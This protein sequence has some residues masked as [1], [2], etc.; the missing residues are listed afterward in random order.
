MLGNPKGFFN[1]SESDKYVG[2]YISKEDVSK[3]LKVETEAL[4]Q[5]P[6]EKFDNG[7]YIDERV[8][9]KLWKD[10]AIPGAVPYKYGNA[11][12]SIDEF[13]LAAIIRQSYPNAVVEHQVPWGRKRIDMK[14]AI[15]GKSTFIEFHGPGH[16]TIQ[17]NRVPEDPFE[18][19]DAIESA[20][21]IECVVW[22][23]WIQRCSKNL[24]I[25]IEGKDDQGWGA[26]WSTKVHFGEFYFENSHNII[27]QLNAQ[28][29]I[30]DNI[31]YFYEIDGFGRYKPEHPIVK[32]I[33]QGRIKAGNYRLIPK[34]TPNSQID[35]WL[36]AELQTIKHDLITSNF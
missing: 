22:P 29:S 1:L 30:H 24:S 25:V 3:I 23:Y 32:S 11:S 2:S 31:G 9:G 10:G 34:G 21:G 14:V 5:L 12:A 18:R 4:S 20:F 33:R 28:F 13:I 7:L 15:D 17:N 26:L 35:C 6:F 27:K 8:L 19:K 16:F 36:P